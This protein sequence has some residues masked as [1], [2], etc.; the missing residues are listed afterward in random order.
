MSSLY[1]S[2]HVLPKHLGGS[3]N[4]NN[5]KRVTILEHVQIHKELYEQ[6]GRWQDKL[7]WMG[8]AGLIDKQEILKQV[9]LEGAR[10]GA[11]RSNEIQGKHRKHDLSGNPRKPRKYSNQSGSKNPNAKI[12]EITFPTGEKII[13]KCLVDFCKEN[14]L[15]MKTLNKACS[16]GSTT[17]SGYSIIKLTF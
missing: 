10:L 3:D 4:P 17:T 12:Y 8:L 7:A 5:L 16:R 9:M 11:K 2:H 6:Y 15:N 14:N 1:H 13:T